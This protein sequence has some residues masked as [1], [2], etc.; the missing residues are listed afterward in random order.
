MN[1][2]KLDYDGLNNDI[3]LLTRNVKIICDSLDKI[4]S[5]DKV[6][7]PTWKSYA[8]SKASSTAQNLVLTP[9][10]DIKSKLLLCIS[11]LVNIT[12]SFDN[13]E[14]IIGNDLNNWYSENLKLININ[15]INDNRL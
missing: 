10:E 3:L 12:D 6:I 5:I 15:H 11:S 4:N 8:A 13:L 1:N 7:P 9:I 2:V 14:N